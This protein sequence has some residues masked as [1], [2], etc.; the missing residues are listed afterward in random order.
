MQYVAISAI[1]RP[2]PCMRAPLH[3]LHPRTTTDALVLKTR[4]AAAHREEESMET[5]SN[6][7]G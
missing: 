7:R 5:S 2:L 1:W 4:A 6:W 3:R